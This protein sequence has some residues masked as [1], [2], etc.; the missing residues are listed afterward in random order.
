MIIDDDYLIDVVEKFHSAVETAK[1]DSRFEL[2]DRMS[3]FPYGCCDDA[4]DLLAYYLKNEHSINAIGFCGT[5]YCTN[6]EGKFNHEWLI[7]EG[8]IIDITYG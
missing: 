5:Y 3:R 7:Y 8:L 2:K 1:W 4:C 6:P